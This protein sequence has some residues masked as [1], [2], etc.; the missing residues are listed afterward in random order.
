MSIFNPVWRVTIGGVQYQKAILANL[1]ITSGRTN[2]YEQAQAGYTNLEI[3]NLD[4]SN[5]TIQIN[6]AVTIELQDS[7]STFVPIFG[8]TVVEF[9]IGIAA[10]G[11]VGINQSI[12][13]TALGALARLPKVLTDGVLV[14]DHDGDQIY[15]VLSDL[16]LNT[17]NEVPAALQWN[18]YNATTTWANAE[19]LG[20]G[21]ID[22]PGEYEL[23]KR[24]ASRIDVYSLV[25]ALATSGLGYIYENAQGQISYAAAL[26]RSLYLAT[27]GYTDLSAAQALANSLSIQTRSGDIRNEITIQYKENSTLE[28]TDSDPASILAYGNLAQIITTTIE[29]QTDAEDQ[30]AFYLTLRA[31]P[32]ANFNQITFELTNSEIDDGD[33]DSLINIFMGLPLRVNELPLNM[34]A[35]TYLG[36]VEGWTWRAAYNTVSVTAILSPVA[37]SLQAMQWQDVSA[38]ESWNTISGGLDWAS[39]LVVA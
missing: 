26:H 31:Y 1:V 34:A 27:N 5:V 17:W 12:S 38:A 9:D 35:G 10:S 3:I 18:T 19:N 7:T 23:A 29:N 6:D 20:L 24:N 36:F 16:L 2:I 28:V 11:V 8:G 37:F 4:Q 25:S 14:K 13:I 39:A 21:E 33:R 15:S 22:R 30:A 32:Q